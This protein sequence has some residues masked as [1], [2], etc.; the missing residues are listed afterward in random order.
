M[1]AEQRVREAYKEYTQ[2]DNIQLLFDTQDRGQQWQ[3]IAYPKCR[4]LLNHEFIN[5]PKIEKQL[6]ILGAKRVA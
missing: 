6:E 3:H 4:Q 5:F 1:E 2:G